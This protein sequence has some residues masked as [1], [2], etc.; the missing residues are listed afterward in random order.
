MFKLGIYERVGR[1]S[2]I[3]L[4]RIIIISIRVMNVVSQLIQVGVVFCGSSIIII[5]ILGSSIIVSS[6]FGI[7]IEGISEKPM[8]LTT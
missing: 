2:I 5:S 8:N 7:T 3:G 6:N 4:G 1:G